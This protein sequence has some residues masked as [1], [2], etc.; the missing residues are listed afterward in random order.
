MKAAMSGQK[1][2]LIHRLLS[3]WNIFRA[4]QTGTFGN[5]ESAI[6]F[7]KELSKII[8]THV[9]VE[10]K[11]IKILDLGCGQT[12]TQTALFKTDGADVI[13]ID[14]EVATYKMNLKTFI[15]VIRTNGVERAIKSLL[16]HLLFDKRYFSKLSLQ[17]GKTI[18]F[19]QLDIRLMNAASL[20][21][22]ANYFD[23]VYSAWVFEHIDNV[24]AAIKEVNRVLKPSGIAWIGVHLFPSLSGGHHLDWIWADKSESNNVPPWD[25]LL[26][27]K[28]PVN[29]YLNRLRL[30]QY[31]VIF[32]EHIDV[33][34]EKLTYE[35][36]KFL[37][38]ETQKILQSKGYM[39]EDLLT[40]SVIFLCR[41]KINTYRKGN[42]RKRLRL[43]RAIRLTPFAK[44]PPLAELRIA[45]KR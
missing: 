12:A 1:I 18:P 43:T 35:G 26:D 36:E 30:D 21:F 25:H 27:N 4:Y 23:F 17:Y 19:D 9:K 15:R 41:K 39:R 10:V 29:T 45:R 31:R 14:M 3:S 34:D 44:I 5:A 20:F 32:H 38:P 16:R 13:G 40:R 24:P 42:D 7:H 6:D 28:Y 37:I 22:P 11:E 8:K 33:F 2:P